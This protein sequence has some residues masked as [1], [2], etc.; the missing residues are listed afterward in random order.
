M[1]QGCNS[2]KDYQLAKQRPPQQIS[3]IPNLFG[4]QIFHTISLGI[5]P[6]F[7]FCATL[8]LNICLRVAIF[9]RAPAI[10]SHCKAFRGITGGKNPV[11]VWKLGLNAAS[12]L[13]HSTDLDNKIA[14]TLLLSLPISLVHY[15]ERNPC[16]K[17]FWE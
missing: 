2:K 3:Y 13:W 5:F 15:W 7:P 14:Q 6:T 12:Q 11:S 16:S 4:I 1:N 9:C 8:S 10:H 17:M